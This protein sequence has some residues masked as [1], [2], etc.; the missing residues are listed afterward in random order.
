MQD[1]LHYPESQIHEPHR[2]SLPSNYNPS[3][4]ASQC[5][6]ISER[7]DPKHWTPSEAHAEEQK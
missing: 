5:T 6:R 3:H 2:T 1:D 4:Y 7:T